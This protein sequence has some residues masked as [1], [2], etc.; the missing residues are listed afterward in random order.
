M[1]RSGHHAHPMMARQKGATALLQ[2]N[3]ILLPVRELW[4]VLGLLSSEQRQH[5]RGAREPA[6]CLVTK[7]LCF[8]EVLDCGDAANLK[9]TFDTDFSRPH[10]GE[11]LLVASADPSRHAHHSAESSNA[12]IE[13]LGIWM[14][15]MTY[16]PPRSWK[17]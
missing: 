13:V 4:T 16:R 5:R 11:F 8:Q 9:L 12:R 7:Q 10:R 15:S 3:V 2:A 6:V 1:T 14:C 17:H